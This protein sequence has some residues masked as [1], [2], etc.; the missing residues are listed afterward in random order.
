MDQRNIGDF[1]VFPIGLGCMGLSAFYGPPTEQAEAINL[2]HKAIDLGVNHFD[3]AEMYG[4][5]ANEKLLG[6][7]FADRREK[8][9]IATKFGPKFLFDENGKPTGT[10][11]DGTPENMRR[12]VENSLR[13]LQTDVIDLYY[14]HRVDPKVPIEETVGAMGQLVGEGKV[15]AIGLSEAS[16]ETIKRAHATH[17]ISAVQS[18]Y[19]I[20]SRD[21]ETDILPTLRAI[22]ATLVAYSPLG[23]GLLTG[24]MTTD[25]KPGGEGEYRQGAMQPRFADGAYEANLALVDEVKAVASTHD[26]PPGQVALAWVLGRADNIVAIPGTTKLK[27]LQS[28][29][30]AADIALSGDEI[31]R[32]NTLADKVQGAR[33]NEQGMSA[34]NR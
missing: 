30:G 20:F 28:N 10:T 2:L 5:G 3:T 21:I 26:A 29:L 27:N 17:P 8:V 1:S 16:A 25:N 6:E 23:R 12:A 22:G 19:S 7:A 11:I 33:Y 32:L 15:R 31:G 18:E 14:L 9:R 24:A 13:Y 4:M 34:V